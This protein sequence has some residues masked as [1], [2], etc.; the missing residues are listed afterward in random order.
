[1]WALPSCTVGSLRTEAAR[2]WHLR[3]SDAF[4][5]DSS[6]ALW[7]DAV[8][9]IDA[10]SASSSLGGGGTGDSTTTTN[11]TNT[12][13]NAANTMATVA[14]VDDD[15]DDVFVPSGAQL[16]P[17]AAAL[18]R[19]FTLRLRDLAAERVMD[20]RAF[21][22]VIR[23]KGGG[24][25]VLTSSATA[26]IVDDE[27]SSID[28]NANNV[29]MTTSETITS[30]P[31]A[32]PMTFA[33]PTVRRDAASACALAA[34]A[35][36][37]PRLWRIFTYYAAAGDASDPLA[38]RARQWRCMLDDCGLLRPHATPVDSKSPNTTAGGVGGG[39]G[40]NFLSLPHLSLQSL[41]YV[42]LLVPELMQGHH[43]HL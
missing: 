8:R 30:S 25:G 32:P 11:T 6:G 41:H 7:P 22:S 16:P 14:A 10:Y 40:L 17:P 34:V 21:R 19:L 20:P 1:M 5:V 3:P 24:T 12:T 35:S 42:Y 15:D 33:A 31:P 36:F 2:F 13:N 43:R 18:A 37:E 28:D 4:L 23:P 38:L 26:L 9:V 27:S 39:G 29:A